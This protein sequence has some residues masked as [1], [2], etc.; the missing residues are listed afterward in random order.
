MSKL[1]TIL[2]LEIVGDIGG[3]GSVLK[4]RTRN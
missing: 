1:D 2:R 3:E 4:F